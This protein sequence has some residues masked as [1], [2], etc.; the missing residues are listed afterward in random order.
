MFDLLRKKGVLHLILV[1]NPV[2]RLFSPVE[3]LLAHHGKLITGH[4]VSLVDDASVFGTFDE[5][6]LKS[7][8]NHL[9]Q[10]LQISLVGH[11]DGAWLI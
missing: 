7:A 10:P 5:V 2:I 11:S 6:T 8:A 1:R 4:R 9:A 3:L